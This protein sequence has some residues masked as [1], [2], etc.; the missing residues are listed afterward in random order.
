MNYLIK[1]KGQVLSA[2]L[3]VLA[4]VGLQILSPKFLSGFIDSAEGGN[5]LFIPG[6]MI[7]GYF[8]TVLLQK[9][10][11]VLEE[12]ISASLGG[13]ITNDVRHEMLSH[14]LDLGMEKHTGYSSGEIMTRLDEDV[15]GVYE[16]LRILLLKIGTSALLLAGV[17]IVISLENPWLALILLAVSI[18]SIWCF[19]KIS[20]FG[21]KCFQRSNQAAAVFNGILKDKL[22]NLV[23]IHLAAADGP[24][25]LSLKEAIYKR[26][27]ESLPAGLIYGRLWGASTV[28]ETISIGCTLLITAIFWDR[29]ILSLGTA[30]LF[31]NYVNLIFQPLNSFR[32]YLGELQNAG[33]RKKRVEG[34]L[35]N[36]TEKRARCLPVP[37]DFSSLTVENLYFSYDSENEVLHNISFSVKAG[38]HVGLMGETGC[39]KT[40]L[41]KL[42]AGLYHCQHGAV[43]VNGIPVEKFDPQKLRREIVY[44]PQKVQ[45]MHA[46]LRDN[47]TLFDSRIRDENILAAINALELTSW[48]A[49]FPR[50]LDTPLSSGEGSIS[51]GEARFVNII[52]LFLRS[53]QVIILDEITANLDKQRERD[54]DRAIRNLTKNKTVIMI[55]HH[56]EILESESRILYMKKGRIQKQE[57]CKGGIPDGV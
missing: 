3:I 42:L 50:G 51:S 25:L 46:S 37:A 16:Y 55:S 56:A 1:Y 9:A 22:D 43:L 44:C 33:A 57:N 39:G 8:F 11:S 47:I 48:F 13:R 28:M 49:G 18:L 5:S 35:E 23:E 10:A 12:Y 26:F 17:L 41:V 54:L 38:E 31:Y 27:G 15:E 2:A 29:G 53:P 30:Y 7:T 14:F 24:A 40:T 52:R 45:L 6:L 4:N 19:K 34:F 32:N 20:D 36:P 21:T